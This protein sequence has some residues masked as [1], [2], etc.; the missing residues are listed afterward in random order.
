MKFDKSELH[1]RIE[2]FLEGRLSEAEN[3]EFKEQ[4]SSD[5]ELDQ[6]YRQRIAIGKT[7]MKA[8]EY[9]ETRDSVSEIIREA[10]SY[11]KN[12][13]FI[14][15]AAAS[16]LVLLSVS[17]IV[18]FNRYPAT[19]TGM[20]D[21]HQGAETPVVPH[22][23]YAEEKAAIHFL[24][25]LKMLAP[26]NNKTCNRNDSI[27]FSWLSKADVE[28]NLII[29]NQNT[30]KTVYREKIKIN[31]GKFVL[32]KNFLPDGKYQWFIEG[33]PGKEKFRVVSSEIL[34]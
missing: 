22:L 24:D 12:K 20:A 3:L 2:D 34:N 23:K 26:I 32:E 9:E 5:K 14:W 28:S 15:S 29:E 30:G 33:F 4:L 13:L 11:K 19:Q 31:S 17:G 6:L 8:K 27:V 7:W 10:K 16:M 25:E 18:I 21:K 1:D